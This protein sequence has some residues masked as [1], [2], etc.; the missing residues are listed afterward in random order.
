MHR[1]PRLLPAL[2]LAAASLTAQ[3]ALALETEGTGANV[4]HV[5][6]VQYPNLHAPDE[7]SHG[8]DLEFATLTVPKDQAKKMRRAKDASRAKGLQRTYSFAGAYGDGLQVIDV[9]EPQQSRRVATWDCGISQGDVQVFHRADLGGRTFAT[10]T[11]DDGYDFHPDS[12]CAQGP[13]PRP[14]RA[15]RRRRARSSPT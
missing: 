10:F 1:I 12:Q 11:H 14:A 15:H 13:R 8:T 9:T 2:A 6:N 4:K 7:V 3:P 5:R